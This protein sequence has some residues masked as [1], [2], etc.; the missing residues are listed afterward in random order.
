MERTVTVTV[1]VPVPSAPRPAVRLS[2]EPYTLP[3][4]AV[5]WVEAIA[6]LR[7]VVG[8]PNVYPFREQLARACE[9]TARALREAEADTGSS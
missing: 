5:E 1:T 6:A 7:G 9:R 4:D 2:G 8:S 3:T